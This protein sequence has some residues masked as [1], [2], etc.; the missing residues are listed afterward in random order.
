MRI[1]GIY[2][3]AN[4]ADG[5]VYVGSSA[6]ITGR[7]GDHKKLLRRGKH[8]SPHLQSAWNKYGEDSFDFEVVEIVDDRHRILER[9]QHWIDELK[10]ALPD[11]GYNVCAVSAGR[12][13]VPH[14]AEA[15][16]KMS[17][18]ATGRTHTVESREKMSKSQR[19]RA[20]STE[21]REKLKTIMR[22]QHLAGMRPGLDWNGRS[23]S[24]ETKKALSEIAK[25][26]AQPESF[27]FAGRS[28]SAET[29]AKIS[30]ASSRPRG[31]LSPESLAKRREK[32]AL[33]R[34]EA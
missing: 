32:M 27:S 20:V 33:K 9:E 28:H 17:A 10:A 8:H 6:N 18:A 4:L 12:F 31:P 21:T 22:E 26:R 2:K 1:S 15:K 5:K 14:S 29:K 11:F 3:I 19:G 24:D 13:G 34:L 16:A 23:H 25:A 30:A 7:F